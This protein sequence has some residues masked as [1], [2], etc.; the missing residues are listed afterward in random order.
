MIGCFGKVPASADFVSLHGAAQEVRE[1]DA[2]LQGALSAMQ[3]REDWRELFDRLPVCL[4]SYRA[5]NGNWLLGGLISARDFSTRRYPFFIFQTL[6]A[7]EA[8]TLVNPFTLGE[9]F[10]GQIKPLLHMAV[11][12]ESTSVLFERIKALRP[13][14]AQDFELFRRVHDKF[15]VNF[16][17]RDITRSLEDSHPEFVSNAVLTRLRALQQPMQ[18]K[19]GMAISLPLPAERG[20]KNP[21]A[22]LWID[23]LTRMKRADTA[24]QIS[25][26]ADDFMRPKLLCF[27]SRNSNGLYRV[28]TGT[29][30]RLENYDVL[31]P[32][33]VFDEHHRVSTFP[34]LDRPLYDVIDR[35]VDALDLKSV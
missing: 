21:I 7:S 11:Q 10:C 16:N 8:Q 4:F 6:K 27:A 23:W 13:L 2:W 12:G 30:E 19:S 3:H 17:L 20:L 5:R 15:L 35:F 1:F 26:L 18:H 34:E 31:A 29:S 32:F 25:V 28:L 33:D 24:P 22:D 9:L 14:Q